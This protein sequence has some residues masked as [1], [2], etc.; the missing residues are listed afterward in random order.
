MKRLI[1]IIMLV[2]SIGGFVSCTNSNDPVEILRERIN[3][4]EMVEYVDSIY[5]AKLLFPC[6]FQVDSIGKYC[7]SFSYSDDN[8]KE[9]ILEYSI[10]PPRLID[11]SKEAVHMFSDSLTISSKVKKSSFILIQEYEYL[12]QIKSVFKYYK[13]IHG[14]A[15]YTLTYEKKY[16][17]SVERL[18]NMVKDWKIYSKDHPEWIT[19]MFDFI[20][21]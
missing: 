19:D 4:A 9:L 15:C 1:T 2:L 17:E 13:T 14:W 20:D 6:F 3:N 7:A 10:L 21:F 16:E 8:V 11:N 5:G 18:I 12:P